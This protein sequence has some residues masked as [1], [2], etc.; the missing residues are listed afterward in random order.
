MLEA[1]VAGQ[2]DPVGKMARALGMSV[3]GLRLADGAL[4]LKLHRGRRVEQIRV[5]KGDGF[6]MERTVLQLHYALDGF[7]RRRCPGC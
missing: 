1:A 7:R 2:G 6:D 4:V 5:L 3:A